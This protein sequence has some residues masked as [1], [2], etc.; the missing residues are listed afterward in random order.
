MSGS[1]LVLGSTKGGQ[2]PII[3][4][5]TGNGGYQLSWIQKSNDLIADN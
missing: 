3:R 4:F 2:N 1:M 5:K